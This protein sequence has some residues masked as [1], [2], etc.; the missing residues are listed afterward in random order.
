MQDF[1][2]AI[3]KVNI[4]KRIHPEKY[5]APTVSIMIPHS[6]TSVTDSYANKLGSL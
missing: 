6:V 1:N 5:Q 4:K 3:Y 2:F